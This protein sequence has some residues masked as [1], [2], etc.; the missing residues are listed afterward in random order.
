VEMGIATPSARND[1]EMGIATP[2][3]RN[4]VG[5]GGWIVTRN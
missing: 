5:M 4:D 3:A 1:V 2:S